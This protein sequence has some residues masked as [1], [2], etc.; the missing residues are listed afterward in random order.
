MLGQS[1]RPILVKAGLPIIRFYDLRHS[2]A[3]LLLS[4]KMW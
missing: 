3:S 1:F 2:A 4:M